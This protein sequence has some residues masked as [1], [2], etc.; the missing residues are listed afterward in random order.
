MTDNYYNP[1]FPIIRFLNEQIK[2]EEQD[3][4]FW[5]LSK[6]IGAQKLHTLAVQRLVAFKEVLEF[7][8]ETFKPE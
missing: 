3:K 1:A 6:T 5:A 8:E 4:E 7:V 2:R